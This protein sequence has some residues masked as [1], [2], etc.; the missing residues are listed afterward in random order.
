M[1]SCGEFAGEGAGG[2]AAFNSSAPCELR[3]VDEGG[4]AVMEASERI[5]T[6]VHRPRSVTI[7]A[8]LQILQS[9]ALILQA[10]AHSTETPL[11]LPPALLETL[12]IVPPDLVQSQVT[13]IVLVVLA[14]AGLF[15]SLALLN[16]RLW[17]K[18]AAVLLQGLALLSSLVGYLRGTPNFL[19]MLIGVV[20][21][22]YLNQAE[23]HQ[24]FR[25]RNSHGEAEFGQG[26]GETSGME[27]S[28]G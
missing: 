10:A 17:A 16:M 6:G 25:S 21:V 9:A 18:Q 11:R 3:E 1:G 28:R 4:F 24:A 2:T 27:R 7:L 19:A 23:V 13:D 5:T 12:Q 26:A 22:L 8:A 20:I 14:L 15:T